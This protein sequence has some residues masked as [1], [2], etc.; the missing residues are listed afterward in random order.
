MKI[1]FKLDD[2][3]FILE[4][5]KV[6]ERDGDLYLD[7]DLV[8]WYNIPDQGWFVSGHVSNRPKDVIY[9]DSMV[10]S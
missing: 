6:V 7:G 2:R 1:T 10:I 4:G 3:T 9:W 5:S 8:G